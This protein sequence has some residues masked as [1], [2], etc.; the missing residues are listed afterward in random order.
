[1]SKVYVCVGTSKN[2]TG[3]KTGWLAVSTSK[4]TTSSVVLRNEHNALD[5]EIHY[6][7]IGQAQQWGYATKGREFSFPLAYNIKCYTITCG[8]HYNGK[9]YGYDQVVSYN[10]S[11]FTTYEALDTNI[12]MLWISIG[13]QQ[14]GV[15]KCE[16]G[17]IWYTI[18]F[19]ISFSIQVFGVCGSVV[20]ITAN[21]SASTP[22]T[23]N[24][25][26]TTLTAFVCG[27]RDSSSDWG[28]FWIAIGV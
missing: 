5:A 4:L 26:G 8:V 14:W 28:M 18:N 24:L 17:D 1:M 13:V 2:D 12:A 27:L 11:G 15:V 22:V 9:Q 16:Q 10:V 3:I 20:S 21:N 23:W 6:I 7:V 19:P 25:I